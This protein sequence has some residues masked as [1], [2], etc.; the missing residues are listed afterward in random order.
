MNYLSTN[1]VVGFLK[2]NGISLSNADV[3]QLA[4]SCVFPN[5]RK[6]SQ[7]RWQIPEEDITVFLTLRKSKQKKYRW[8]TA[9]SILFII[10]IIGLVSNFKD[11]LDF[12]V[13]Y[14][15]PVKSVPEIVV[16]S[17]DSSVLSNLPA[18]M[19]CRNSIEVANTSD[20][21][22]S[23][24]AIGTELRVDDIE[25]YFDANNRPY[26][27]SNERVRLLVSPWQTAPIMEDI[28][29]KLADI[30]S[31]SDFALATGEYLP[32]YINA[33]STNTIEVDIT[34]TFESG[35]PKKVWAIHHLEFPDI[36]EIITTQ[37]ECPIN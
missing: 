4:K 21:P 34:M 28:F 5:A 6:D 15:F 24:I 2:A 27:W 30:K 25:V 37:I 33:H 12:I 31:I 19:V 22:T 11:G 16:T 17:T 8:I 3:A 7:N 35:L 1:E 18:F 36:A 10:S 32:A 9:T 23:V 26:F 14:M 13:T 20:V 29:K